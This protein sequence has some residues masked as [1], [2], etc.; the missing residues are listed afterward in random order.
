MGLLDIDLDALADP[1]P[2]V[3]KPNLPSLSKNSVSTEDTR[4]GVTKKRPRKRKLPYRA[5]VIVNGK[6][7]KGKRVTRDEADLDVNDLGIGSEND[8]VESEQEAETNKEDKDC[9]DDSDNEQGSQV[10]SSLEDSDEIV[11]DIEEEG[12]E[13]GRGSQDKTLKEEERAAAERLAEAEERDRNRAIAIK[14]QKVSLTTLV[15]FPI[16]LLVCS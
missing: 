8:L 5:D 14:Q 1:A 15:P 2:D 3:V 4:E 11:S 10:D 6:K 16:S 7:Y 9:P 12:Q 13:K